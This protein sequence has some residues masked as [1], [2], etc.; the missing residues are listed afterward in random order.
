MSS[1]LHLSLI[2]SAAFL[3][4]SLP[5]AY[6]ML[7]RFHEKDIRLEGSGNVGARNLYEVTNSKALGIIV[8]VIDLLKGLGAIV[9]MRWFGTDGYWTEL[10][11]ASAVVAGHNYSPW[12]QFKGGRGLAT[13]T[14]V[15]LMMN[16][17]LILYWCVAWLIVNMIA[18]NVHLANSIATINLPLLAM[19]FQDL[20]NVVT[21]SAVRSFDVIIYVALS[22]CVLILSKHVRPLLDFLRQKRQI[23]MI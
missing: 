15:A 11:A 22:I 3:L 23:P 1:Y 16:P 14:G 17:L 4:G 2:G 8:L 9:L 13:A 7:R 21:S 5:T 19:L 20:T 6:I 18:K 12:I 10:L